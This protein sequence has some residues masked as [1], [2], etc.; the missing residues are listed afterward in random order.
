MPRPLSANIP[1]TM[2]QRMA[3]EGIET[4]KELEAK[5]GTADTSVA[6]FLK[7]DKSSLKLLLNILHALNYKCD[8]PEFQ[9]INEICEKN[10]LNITEDSSIISNVKNDGEIKP[11]RKV[12]QKRNIQEMFP[13]SSK[14][15]SVA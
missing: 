11:I 2:R 6:K 7:T 4:I 3:T 1:P 12:A 9:L 13:K 8:S 10:H 14:I 15:L 5:A